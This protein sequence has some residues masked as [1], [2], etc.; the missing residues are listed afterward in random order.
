MV[1]ILARALE[2][3]E[4]KMN[5]IDEVFRVF[6]RYAMRN[7]LPKEVYVRFTKKAIKTQILQ[8]ARDDPLRYKGKEI[9]VLKQVP[10]KVRE[11]RREYQFLT[12]ILIKKEVNYR[13][14]VPEGLTFIW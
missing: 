10:R 2:I 4:E 3:P 13:W 12:K 8:R 11:L 14:L 9:I 1:E 7:K 6:T 5:S